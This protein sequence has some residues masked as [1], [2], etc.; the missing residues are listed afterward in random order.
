MFTITELTKVEFL[1]CFDVKVQA[2]Q[3]CELG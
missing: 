1:K 3:Q 2:F